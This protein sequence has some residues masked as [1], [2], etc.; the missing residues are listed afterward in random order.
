MRVIKC[1]ACGVTYNRY[2]GDEHQNNSNGLLLVNFMRN[3]K[4]EKH[5]YFDLC[6]DCMRKL[7]EFLN[8][9]EISTLRDPEVHSYTF[10]IDHIDHE[11]L[12]AINENE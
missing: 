10:H 9:E 2:D 4:Y 12:G 3:G 11:A 7:T 8:G 1:D 6:P 5:G